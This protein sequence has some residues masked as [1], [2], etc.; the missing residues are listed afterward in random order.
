MRENYFHEAFMLL[1]SSLFGAF[2]LS[3]N[4]KLPMINIEET[5]ILQSFLML[6]LIFGV[7]IIGQK[8]TAYSLDCTT[9]TK[10]IAFRKFWFRPLRKYELSKESGVPFPAWLVLPLILVFATNSIIKW[11]A[12]LNFD[13]ESSA[14]RIR[15]R[16]KE[17]TEYDN[18]KIALA[19]PLAVLLLGIISKAFGFGDFALLC[20]WIAFLSILPIGIGFKLLMSS[21]ILWIFSFILIGSILLL[22]K[23][24]GAFAVLITAVLFA[25]LATVA[26]YILYES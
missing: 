20:V 4:V 11:L 17:I 16:W 12:I 2:I 5:T 19:G 14:S 25:V 6:L 1:A 10:L 26:Y 23:T 8:I 3:L 15:R 22:I 18:A 13:V 9:S 21:R 7:F 24:A